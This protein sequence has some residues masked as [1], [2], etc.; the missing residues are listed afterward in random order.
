MHPLIRWIIA[1]LSFLI[2][3]SYVF[4]VDGWSPALMATTVWIIATVPEAHFLD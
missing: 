1:P 4:G 3:M 2:V